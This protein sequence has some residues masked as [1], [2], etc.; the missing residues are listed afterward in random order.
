M[1]GADAVTCWFRY[2]RA[3][4]APPQET[5]Q[6]TLGEPQAFEAAVSGLEADADYDVW[7]LSDHGDE[8]WSGE[9]LTFTTGSGFS[10]Q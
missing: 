2:R 1:R 5:E 6:Q 4:E 8:R 10:G 7:A 3:G 9:I